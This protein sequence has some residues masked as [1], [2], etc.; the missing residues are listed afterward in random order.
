MNE[1]RLELSMHVRVCMYVCL[2]VCM[3][4]C[5]RVC[6]CVCAS[7]RVYNSLD[8]IR[9]LF[10]LRIKRQTKS[11]RGSCAVSYPMGIESFSKGETAER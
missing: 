10:N 1:V 2:Y 8:E 5:I 6:V 7:A 11:I 4:V 9:R 3:Y